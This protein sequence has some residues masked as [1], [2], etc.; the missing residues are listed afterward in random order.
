L[1]DEKKCGLLVYLIDVEG[2]GK[3]SS[4]ESFEI[5]EKNGSSRSAFAVSFSLLQTHK[6]TQK[7]AQSTKEHPFRRMHVLSLLISPE[8]KPKRRRHQGMISRSRGKI[9]LAGKKENNW[10]RRKKINRRPQ[11]QIRNDSKN[12]NDRSR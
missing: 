11:K 8:L 9:Q 1:E 4:K 12:N 6:S 2:G 10:R 3:L 5:E 7:W